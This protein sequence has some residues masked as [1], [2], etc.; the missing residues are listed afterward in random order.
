MATEGRVRNLMDIRHLVSPDQATGV[1][2][3]KINSD[4]EHSSPALGVLTTT[5]VHTPIIKWAFAARIRHIRQNDAIL[6]RES[7]IE[8]KRYTEDYRLQSVAFKSDFEGCIQAAQIIGPPRPPS[9]AKSREE[10]INSK[11]SSTE[12]PAMSSTVPPQM[13]ALVLRT[14][15]EWSLY[16]LFAYNGSFQE[17]RFVTYRHSLP[18]SNEITAQLGERVAVDPW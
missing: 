16:I 5:I 13:L 11:E 9:D 4:I 17:V 18:P 12:D 10:A 6:I 2:R 8:I 1:E 14:E 15:S 7:S 3:L